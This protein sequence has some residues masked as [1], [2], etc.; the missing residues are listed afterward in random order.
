M[1]TYWPYFIAPLFVYLQ[2][3]QTS[4]F[5]VSGNPEW[6]STIFNDF[7]M[8]QPGIE[9]VT[10][11]D[12]FLYSLL[13]SFLQTKASAKHML[14]AASAFKE[15]VHE[16]DPVALKPPKFANFFSLWLMDDDKGVNIWATV[17]KKVLILRPDIC[18]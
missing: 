11:H 7:G 6:A 2:I 3:L 10:S 14:K 12:C 13:P 15:R 16:I 1:Q 8:P 9:S 17:C 5:P 4:D 18:F